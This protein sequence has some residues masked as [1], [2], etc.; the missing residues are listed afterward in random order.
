VR[1]SSGPELREALRRVLEEVER[2]AGARGSSIR[3]KI[4]VQRWLASVI[5][6]FRGM[7]VKELCR[8]TG[9]LVHIDKD[10]SSDGDGMEQVA[11]VQGPPGN[12]LDVLAR[13]LQYQQDRREVRSDSGAG[14]N[15]A[16]TA[17]GQGEGEE[18]REDSASCSPRGACRGHGDGEEAEAQVEAE[19]PGEDG[20]ASADG[21]PQ[22]R[23]PSPPPPWRLEEHPEAPGE[24][25][26]L[27]MDTGETTWEL[28]E[29]VAGG[30]GEAGSGAEGEEDAESCAGGRPP[31]PPP[32]WKC[33]EH[34]E[35]P[36]EWYYLNEDTGE[37][38]WELPEEAEAPCAGSGNEGHPEAARHHRRRSRA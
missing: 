3:V 33:M 31:T 22:G 17:S 1:G 16:W 7:N 14:G 5:I 8:S 36:G 37:T 10:V 32:P 23:P 12:I 9:T 20:D 19:E 38:C 29:E 13:I 25:Y 34:P 24:W 18:P 15:G 35:A 6:G 2:H 26:Y 27:N 11:N 21:P 4:V 28:P 30:E